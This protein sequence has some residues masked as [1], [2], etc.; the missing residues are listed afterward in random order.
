MLPGLATIDGR[1]ITADD[2]AFSLKRLLILGQN[3]HG[4]FASIVC[5]GAKL[6]VISDDCPGIAV[7]GDELV[8]RAGARKEFLIQ[9]LAAIDFA[10]IPRSAV[11]PN[12]L[13]ITNMRETSGPYYVDSKAPDGS[14]VLRANP[15]HYHAAA[16][17]P[18]SVVLIPFK[19]SVP[20]AALKMI[21]RGEVDHV[22]T[23][24]GSPVN[25]LLR[26]AMANQSTIGAHATLKIRAT[27]L[28][29]TPRGEA[30][31]SPQERAAI[32]IAVQSVFQ[33]MYATRVGFE[34]ATGFFPALANG[35][36]SD[37]QERK[38]AARPRPDIDASS[39]RFRLGLQKSGTIE[40]WAEPL[41]K[42]LKGAEIYRE[43]NDFPFD[44][45]A[46]SL[47]TPQAIIS[48]V[49]T[50][51]TEDIS[52]VS[53]S[54]VAGYFGMTKSG[55]GKWLA[56][57]M[58]LPKRE[59]RLTKLRELHFEALAS[60]VLVPLTIS[61]FVALIRKPWRMEFPET[62]AGNPLWLIKRP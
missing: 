8:L 16:K 30:E 39:I 23:S 26:F 19:T 52:L 54:V 41:N 6:K 57:Y 9:M 50:G 56:D 12:T 47:N 48:S 34:N 21:E 46:S 43:A 3:T 17:S 7:Q 13:K 32:G 24:N 49:D 38:L 20:N 15:K 18:Q 14:F 36:L 28:S 53:Y 31:L 27:H 58:S 61:P 5:P 59:D 37:E 11:D 25:D 60:S 44:E 55:R 2:A 33:K 40:E 10:V 4:N 45:S 51:F 62:F 22:M 35:A 42:A 29:F 1:P